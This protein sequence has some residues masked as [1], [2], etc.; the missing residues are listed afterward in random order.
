V[1]KP[2]IA[3][4]VYIAIATGAASLLVSE[5]SSNTHYASNGYQDSHSSDLPYIQT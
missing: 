3:A 2:K 4:V 5:L 1:E